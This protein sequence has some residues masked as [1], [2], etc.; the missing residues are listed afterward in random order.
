MHQT[1][2]QQNISSM[3]RL[4]LFSN[5]FFFS[6]VSIFKKAANPY[7]LET[8]KLIMFHTVNAGRPPDPPPPSQS[9]PTA[10]HTLPSRHLLTKS[11][12]KPNLPSHTTDALRNRDI[13][14]VSLLNSIDCL[15]IL[16]L[17]TGDVAASIR[18]SKRNR[19]FSFLVCFC[20]RH[21]ICLSI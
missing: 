14:I 5:D 11:K 4:F 8:A 9:T 20:C 6:F 16:E 21:C 12:T 1:R 3:S 7:A 10:G 17:V 13:V 15:F 19:N 18:P 2:R